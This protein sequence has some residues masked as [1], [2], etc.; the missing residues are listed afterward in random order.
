MILEINET[1]SIVS[2][3]LKIGRNHLN[4][5]LTSKRLPG[6]NHMGKLIGLQFEHFGTIIIRQPVKGTQHH[7][8]V[9]VL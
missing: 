2:D 5:E 3:H 9:C 8:T 1:I 6:G 7:D 4:L